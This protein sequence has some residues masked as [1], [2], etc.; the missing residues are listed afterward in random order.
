V[1]DEEDELDDED[2]PTRGAELELLVLELLVLELLL[3][4]LLVLEPL[5]PVFDEENAVQ[6]ELPERR[7]ELRR[8]SL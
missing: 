3:L 7:E 5:V 2:V 8:R 1:V 4:E 6:A